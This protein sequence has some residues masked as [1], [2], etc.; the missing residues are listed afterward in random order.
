MPRLVF[1]PRALDDL[2]RLV[3]FLV[4]QSLKSAKAS[5]ALIASGLEALRLH[6]LLGRPTEHG[7]REL[8]ISRGRTGYV[9]LYQYDAAADR[10]LVLAVRHQREAGFRDL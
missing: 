6:P 7:L 4:A 10:V 8:L 3:D 9:A 5:A 2:D 1:A